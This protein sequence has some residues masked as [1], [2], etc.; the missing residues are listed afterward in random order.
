MMRAS[1]F[2]PLSRFLL[3]AAALAALGLFFAHDTP[4]AQAQAVVQ[5][6]TDVV[7]T[8]GNGKLVMTWTASTTTAGNPAYV[9]D[10]TS[11]QTVDLQDTRGF[12][13]TDHTTHW[14]SLTSNLVSGTTYTV[15]NLSNGTTYR[16][17]VRTETDTAESVWV[18]ASGTP[19][20]LAAPSDVDISRDRT[21]GG[22]LRVTWGRVSGATGYEA[23]WRLASDASAVGS[24]TAIAAT[25]GTSSDAFYITGL[26]TDTAY[27]FRVRAKDADGGGT[28]SGWHGGTPQTAAAVIWTATL[29]PKGNL[30]GVDGIGCESF[31]TC[32]PLLSPTS[33]IT[34]SGTTFTIE[35]LRQESDGF[36]V[37]SMVQNDTSALQGLN[38]CSGPVSVPL[39]G[40]G[41]SEPLVI[42]RFAT[43][44]G[45][46]ANTQVK[47]RIGSDCA[48]APQAEWPA[49]APRL[50][51][52][53]LSAGDAPLTLIQG[54]IHP[55]QGGPGTTGF[56]SDTQSYM[57]VVP[58]GTS[59]VTLTPEF[60]LNALGQAS[61]ARDQRY[62]GGRP[63][64]TEAERVLTFVSSINPGGSY[65]LRLGPSE[66]DGE[67]LELWARYTE[68][69]VRVYREFPY[70]PD[71]KFETT[72]T[73]L[74]V[75]GGPIPVSL[76][77]EGL[78]GNVLLYGG[79]RR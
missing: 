18:E 35:Q 49:V 47:V 34:V 22:A 64:F 9:L 23:E 77:V 20:A 55:D 3:L 28:W 45:W 71:T 8:P 32:A 10:Y 41:A 57:A 59:E 26:T 56:A 67:P 51:G 27:E 76:S 40:A 13:G 61:S 62:S 54:R 7:A 50:D 60:T 69:I 48:Q 5:P 39:H 17:R 30:Q 38:F 24:D 16:V 31:N 44:M 79:R 58:Y 65:T 63:V 68:V 52:L 21:S 75:Q 4:P 29:T 42:S 66:E 73:I 36:L 6:P 43:H 11:S 14:K 1:S 25:K 12:S 19:T 74:V 2:P 37:L 53:A 72:Y 15:Q 46:T 70:L 33:E 78:T